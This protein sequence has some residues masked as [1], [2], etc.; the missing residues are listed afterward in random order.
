[1]NEKRKKSFSATGLRQA[2]HQMN[3][4]AREFG[5]QQYYL[6]YQTSKLVWVTRARGRKA[7]DFRMI[8]SD[9]LRSKLISCVMILILLEDASLERTVSFYIKPLFHASIFQNMVDVSLEAS[10]IF[11]INKMRRKKNLEKSAIFHGP[12]SVDSGIN[13]GIHM[14][15]SNPL[16]PKNVR[17]LQDLDGAG[18]RKIANIFIPKRRIKKLNLPK[19]FPVSQVR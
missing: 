9:N 6:I 5:T 8:I 2:P 15:K 3:I 11:H 17:F 18:M 12:E 14:K 19:N 13:A 7:W 10:A 4:G 16:N 1:M